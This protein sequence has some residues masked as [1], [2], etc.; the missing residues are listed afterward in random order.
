[1][2]MYEF[3]IAYSDAAG[4]EISPYY[5]IT[6]PIAIF[7]KNNRILEQKNLADRTNLAIR[8]VVSGLDKKYSHYKVAVIQTA[9]IEGASRYFIEGIHTIND[10][11]VVYTTEQNKLATSFDK[12]L[13]DQKDLQHQIIYCFNTV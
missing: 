3:L 2:G 12:L 13:I 7:D 5:S 1:M 8:L 10:N 9:D 11:T 6:N 4:N